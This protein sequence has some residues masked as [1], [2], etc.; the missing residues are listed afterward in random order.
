VFLAAQAFSG[1]Y[2]PF[3]GRY[4]LSAAVLVAPLTTDWFERR[5]RFTRA[6]LAAAIL[7]T[8]FSALGAAL[9][10]TGAPLVTARARGTVYE[11]LLLKDR[12]TQT[13]RQRPTYAPAVRRYEEMVPAGAIVADM[14]PPDSFEYLLWGPRLGRTIVPVAG[15]ALGD[16]VFSRAQYLVF[17]PDLLPPA[18]GDVLLGED[19]WLRM[20]AGR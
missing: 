8:V 9:F 3:R 19:W 1:P 4:F 10:R 20:L 2:D 16:A 15:R 18:A 5:G 11:S 17:T 12:A 13:T 14:L 7:L 6:W